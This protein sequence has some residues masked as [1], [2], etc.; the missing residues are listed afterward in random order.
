MDQAQLLSL[1]G[2][3]Y[4]KFVADVAAKLKQQTSFQDGSIIEPS[5]GPVTQSRIRDI[6]REEIQAK[7]NG[8]TDLDKS[9]IFEIVRGKI[10]DNIDLDQAIEDWMFNNFDINTYIKDQLD[11]SEEVSDYLSDHLSDRVK[12]EVRDLSFS[13]TVD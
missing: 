1:I 2:S 12:D 7:I 10:E 9:M 5:L 4:D 13:V 3:L 8:L 11:I 6:V